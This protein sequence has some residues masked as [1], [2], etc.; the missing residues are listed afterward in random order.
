MIAE[1]RAFGNIDIHD[2]NM[3]L[4]ENLKVIKEQAEALLH[5]MDLTTGRISFGEGEIDK[6]MALREA[7]LDFKSLEVDP[8]TQFQLIIDQDNL[9]NLERYYGM[10]SDTSKNS[11]INA[12]IRDTIIKIKNKGTLKQQ[13]AKVN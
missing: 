5:T 3:Q 1:L 12:M 2:A 4:K 10:M 13:N 8:G 9:D 6:W 11:L 7:I